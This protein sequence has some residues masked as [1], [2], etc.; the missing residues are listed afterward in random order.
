VRGLGLGLETVG[1]EPDAHGVP[2]DAHLRAAERLW[3]IG[4]VNG[5]WP[6]THV[7]KYQG[8]VVAATAL[9][10]SLW[11]PCERATPGRRHRLPQSRNRGS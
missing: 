8:D 4:D 1:V 5:L 6:L 2:V 3:A 11:F 7:G 10:H 9:A